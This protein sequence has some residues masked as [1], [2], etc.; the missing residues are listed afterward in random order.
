MGLN[1]SG[2]C[3]HVPL[4]AQYTSTFR[5]EGP[6][7]GFQI[8]VGWIGRNHHVVF[9][10]SFISS[11]SVPTLQ[12][13]SPTFPISFFNSI[14][15]FIFFNSSITISRFVQLIFFCLSARI[16]RPMILRYPL[17]PLLTAVHEFFRSFRFCFFLN[18]LSS[19]ICFIQLA[20]S[21]PYRPLSCFL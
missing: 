14:V 11:I 8:T 7:L 3:Y 6:C 4:L 18:L 13:C 19:F 20:C 1:Y 2:S 15:N 9:H 21:L 12:V 16:V 17:F 5:I 10:V